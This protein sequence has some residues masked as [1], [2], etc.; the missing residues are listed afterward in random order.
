MF[1]THR[2][3][4]TNEFGG[5]F[6]RL[7]TAAGRLTPLRYKAGR[8]TPLRLKSLRSRFPQEAFD[9]GDDVLG[10]VFE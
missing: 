8:L 9:F 3:F 10:G 1:P 7:R 4:D 5:A 6:T 2:C